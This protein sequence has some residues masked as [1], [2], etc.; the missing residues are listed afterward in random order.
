VTQEDRGLGEYATQD[1]EKIFP[2]FLVLDTSW[3]MGEGGRL[4]AAEEMA[5]AL[6]DVVLGNPS[7]KD[8]VRLEVI[9]FSN[10]ARVLVPFSRP[11]NVSS[12]PA[13]SAEG[14]TAYGEAFSLLRGEI[15]SAV[16]SLRADGYRIL[17]PTVFF[18]TDG[19]PND[20]EQDRDNAF[21]LLQDPDFKAS[22]NIFMF[23]VGDAPE[24]VL[25]RYQARKGIAAKAKGDA[26]EALKSLIPAITQS[27]VASSAGA[28]GGGVVFDRNLLDEDDF[29]IFD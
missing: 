9:Q 5:P 18:I 3:S 12:V 21:D 7:V 29:E 19:E 27:V 16:A 22:P 10:D 4:E 25:K 1:R 13:L 28:D 20:G 8:K 17:R 24:E 23:G 11:D 26:A 6:L 15:E 14:G 2:V